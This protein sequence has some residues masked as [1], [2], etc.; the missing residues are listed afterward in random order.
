M[1]NIWSSWAG[2]A[3]RIVISFLFVPF[4]TSVLGDARYGV[5]VIA[6]Q[7]I[8]YFMLL[9]LGLEKALVRFVSK[10]LGKNDFLR[11]NRTLN[12]TF[13]LYLIAGSIIIVGAWLTATFLFDYFQIGDPALAAEGKSVLI[14]IG[15]F[16][17]FRFYLLPFTAGLVGFQR[18]DV[19]NALHMIE[20]IVRAAVLVWLLLNGY[21]MVAL[22]LAILIV[23]VA[24]QLVAI[25]FLKRL[26]PQ[27]ALGLS[28][29]DKPTAKE[30]FTYSRITFG[31]TVAWLVIFNTDTVLLGL[32]SSAALAG[33]Y[34]PGA[35]LLLHLRNAV[36]VVATPL[37]AAISQLEA[38]GKHEAIQ[39]LYLKG[40][41]YTSYLSFFMAVG[42]ILYARPFV[43]LWL[44]PE[45]AEAAEVMRI[46][47]VSGA[48]FIPQI[49]GNAVLFATDRHGLLLRVLVLEAALKI[50]LSLILIQKYGLIGMAFAAA[51]PQLLLYVSLYPVMLGRALNIS[52]ATIMLTSLR[53]GLMAMFATL[54][55]VVIVRQLLPPTNWPWFFANLA[56]VLV[57]AAAGAYFVLEPADRARVR[58]F[59]NR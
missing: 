56:I 54:P 21:G 49:I 58:A 30:L 44:E 28:H 1:R 11:I 40:L 23:S 52:T 32:L 45:F 37:T 25:I 42:V 16:S 7:T 3:V 13:G 10:H 15:L 12:T 33:V 46:L 4:I 31:I 57:P 55:V 51:V 39:R 17:G 27:T 36:N 18:S 24:R 14:I 6:F 38:E 59:L 50:I 20:E 48:F 2:Y 53:S 9:D 19:S 43:A 34:A 35:Q 47:A 29:F 41:R 5:W 26:H 8:N 22:A